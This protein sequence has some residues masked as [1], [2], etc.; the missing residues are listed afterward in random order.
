MDGS[1]CFWH[2]PFRLLLQ[3]PPYKNDSLA[4]AVLN[5]GTDV[6]YGQTIFCEEL[7]GL[8]FKITCFPSSRPIPWGAEVLYDTVRQYIGDTSG[9]GCSI[10][11]AARDHCPDPGAGGGACD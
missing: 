1:R 7:L 6:L 10:F 5:D 3:D 11:T 8:K 2:C 9:K 4:D